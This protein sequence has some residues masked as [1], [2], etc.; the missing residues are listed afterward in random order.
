MPHAQPALVPLL[1]PSLQHVA[2]RPSSAQTAI[3]AEA[4]SVSELPMAWALCH[5]QGTPGVEGHR[6]GI[7]FNRMC[8]IIGT[9][10]CFED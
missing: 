2:L 3:G 6:T 7:C 4:R 5:G 8:G 1:Q 9:L 10:L